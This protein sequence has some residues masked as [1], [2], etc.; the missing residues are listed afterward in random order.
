MSNRPLVVPSSQTAAGTSSVRWKFVMPTLLVIWILGMVDKVG[1]A[2]VATNKDFL[3]EMHLTHS[4]A[5][6][7]LLM[8]AMLFAYGIGFPIWGVL[9]DRMGPKQCTI[10]GL[11]LW[12]MSTALG[13]LAENF[14]MLLI[15]RIILGLAEAY[16]WPTSNAL[17][18]RWFPLSERGRAKAIWINGIN[19]GLAISGFVVNGLIGSFQWRGVFWFLTL[20]A[21]VICLPMAILFLKNNPADDKR[22]S[23]SELAY[24]QQE[25]LTVERHVE[26]AKGMNSSSFWLAVLVNIANVF[27][28]FG[29]ATWFPS[30]LTTAKH[31]SHATT[32][33][34]IAL[35]FGLCIIMTTVVGS[36][37]D[38]TKRKAIWGLWGFVVSMVLLVAISFVPSA[39][40]DALFLVVAI[41][42]IQGITTL[43][44]HGIMHSFTVTE[45]IGR[46][47]GIMVGISN[48]LAALGPTIMG[49]LIGLA[50]FN[51]AFGFLAVCFLIGAIGHT[52]L[53][54][55]GY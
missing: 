3:Q 11:L 55:Q 51:M 18:A 44:N 5:L 28:V 25:Q 4:P 12:A 40:Y 39:L 22:V 1:V 30:Y 38:K 17:T 49:A 15:S 24:I 45:H 34:Y 50:G 46:D 9:V 37:T 21:L 41:I 14:T 16:L 52:V 47:N 32:S 53:A 43:V 7:G 2:V 8:T 27:G 35:A 13:A 26:K 36:F 54:K 31:F 19:I 10:C 42:C 23:P 33:N 6:V 29:L 20:C 48:L